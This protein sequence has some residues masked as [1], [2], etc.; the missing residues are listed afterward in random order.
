M[1]T[2]YMDLWP[3]EDLRQNLC[4]FLH[5]VHVHVGLCVEILTYVTLEAHVCARECISMKNDSVQV[6]EHACL[7]SVSLY[8]GR[9]IMNVHASASMWVGM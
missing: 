1:Y 7:G 9:S 5:T 3:E 6:C 2:S 4:A 8:V